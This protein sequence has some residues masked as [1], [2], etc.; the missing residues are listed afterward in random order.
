MLSYPTQRVIFVD[1][2]G[3]LIVNGRPNQALITW[4]KQHKQEGF[5]INLWSMQGKS[6]AISA[7]HLCGIDQLFDDIL[8]KPGHIIDDKGWTWIKWAKIV[9]P[10]AWATSLR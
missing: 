8:S 10:S 7:A 1:V 4:L 3:T 2:D 5:E 9:Q 6:H